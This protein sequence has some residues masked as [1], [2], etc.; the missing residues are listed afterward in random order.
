MAIFTSNGFVGSIFKLNIEILLESRE[1][2]MFNDFN[3]SSNI[4][5]LIKFCF[6][7]FT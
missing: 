4:L 3:F 1:I 7:L 5:D 2:Y 6:T